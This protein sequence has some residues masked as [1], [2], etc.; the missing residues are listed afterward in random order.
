MNLAQKSIIVNKTGSEAQK[1][2][3]E[4]FLSTEEPEVV[5]LIL[6]LCKEYF[7]MI[8]QGRKSVEIRAACP[9]WESRLQSRTHLVLQ[10]GFWLQYDFNLD[11][12]LS[13]NWPCHTC[14]EHV[15]QLHCC[16]S[17]LPA[18]TRASIVTTQVTIL[19][20]VWV[21]QRSG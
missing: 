3:V 5:T 20:D 19:Q 8:E 17:L 21:Q 1:Y 16:C 7:E 6:P 9:Y 15:L 11:S 4:V 18:L 10:C 12:R 2:S 14:I 13:V